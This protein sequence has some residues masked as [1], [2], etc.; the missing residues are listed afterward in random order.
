MWQEDLP[1]WLL[2]QGVLSPQVNRSSDMQAVDKS[3]LFPSAV[4]LQCHLAALLL[5]ASVTDL[6]SAKRNFPRENV[7]LSQLVDGK[8]QQG[9]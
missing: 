9:G 7:I 5:W 1:S 3:V 6:I 4:A 8:T 2:S